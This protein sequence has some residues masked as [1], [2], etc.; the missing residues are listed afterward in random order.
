MET[1]TGRRGLRKALNGG[2]TQLILWLMM[3]QQVTVLG[4]GMGLGPLVNGWGLD[5]ASICHR[6]EDCECHH[7]LDLRFLV[8]SRA[9]RPTIKICLSPV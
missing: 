3:T 4:R 8:I 5:G 6:V 1:V 7:S 2:R 9:S